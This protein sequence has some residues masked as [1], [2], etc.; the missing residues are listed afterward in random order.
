MP[1]IL[2][3]KAQNTKVLLLKEKLIPTKSFNNHLRAKM[4]TGKFLVVLHT[5]F[6]AITLKTDNSHNFI[7]QCL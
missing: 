3:H 2:K 6:Q 5:W 4:P 1:L 7:H